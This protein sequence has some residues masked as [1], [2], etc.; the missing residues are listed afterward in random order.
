MVLKEEF[1]K[2]GQPLY[3]Q[4]AMNELGLRDLELPTMTSDLAELTPHILREQWKR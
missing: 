1:W 2:K 4:K 3:L